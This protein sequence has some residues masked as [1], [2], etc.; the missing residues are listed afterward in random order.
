M[1]PSPRGTADPRGGAPGLTITCPHCRGT[2]ALEQETYGIDVIC[3][4]GGHRWYEARRASEPMK[5][6]PRV[7]KQHRGEL[8]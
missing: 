3:V 5:H 8:E 1:I 6:L 4:Q 2:L 7:S